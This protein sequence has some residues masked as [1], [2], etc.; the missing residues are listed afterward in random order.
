MPAPVNYRK[1]PAFSTTKPGH[2][3]VVTRDFTD[4]RWSYDSDPTVVPGAQFNKR[5][6]NKVQPAP[7]YG[8]DVGLVKELLQECHEKAPLCAP[9]TVT[10]LHMIDGHQ[11][12]GWAQQDWDYYSCNHP[13]PCYECDVY[14]GNEKI[15]SRNWDGIIVLSGRNTEI[16]PAIARYVV[17]H[18]YGHVVSYALD[19]LRYNNTKSSPGDKV[20][21]EW[22]KVRR[23]PEELWDL[24]YGI[25][26]HHRMP[27]E[28][29][30]NDFRYYVMERETEWWPHSDSVKP[31]GAPGTKRAMTW[32]DKAVDEL[33]TSYKEAKEALNAR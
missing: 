20:I 28:I 33:Q 10:V 19:L 22:A 6:G 23:L 5:Y 32:W 7:C 25:T 11:T 17:P 2:I 14:D 16:H 26:N 4:I 18:E 21:R 8:H 29:F 15:R 3:E 1:L 13:D 31:L 27:G 12:N 24:P 9:V 30:A